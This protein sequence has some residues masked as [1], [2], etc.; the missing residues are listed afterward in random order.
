MTLSRLLIR[1]AV[2]VLPITVLIVVGAVL[3]G[4]QMDT[5]WE[6]TYRVLG[7]QNGGQSIRGMDIERGLSYTLFERTTEYTSIITSPDDR[8]M[9]IGENDPISS[10]QQWL[11]YD[12]DTE[13][14]QI[15]YTATI[16]RQVPFWSP[17][18]QYFV[19]YDAGYFYI[20]AL[21]D[22]GEAYKVT[23][24]DM[25]TESAVGIFFPVRW[26]EDGSAFQ[27]LFPRV[28][29][30]DLVVITLDGGIE[31]TTELDFMYRGQTDWSPDGQHLLYVVSD[32]ANDLDSLIMLG[33]DGTEEIIYQSSDTIRTAYW[34]WDGQEVAVVTINSSFGSEIYSVDI[35]SQQS[36]FIT[37]YTGSRALWADWSPTSAHIFFPIPVSYINRNNNPQIGGRYP[38]DLFVYAREADELLQPFS[39]DLSAGVRWSPD[40]DAFVFQ[41]A[42]TGQLTVYNLNNERTR[43]ITDEGRDYAILP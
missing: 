32:D 29:T 35:A 39:A 8:Y 23:Q 17:D 6:I 5:G 3:I 24:V 33:I 18:G 22:A 20:Y 1:L 9:L 4:G 10:N 30:T 36:R 34:S 15:A 25:G 28:N 31:S 26:R 21:D 12:R 41:S 42:Y 27:V 2:S 7:H 14:T 37:M 40:G 38:V 13:Q 19:Y 11:L 43:Q 16:D